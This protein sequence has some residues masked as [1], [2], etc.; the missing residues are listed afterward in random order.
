[1]STSTKRRQARSQRSD[2]RVPPQFVGVD[3]E[4]GN[5]DGMHRYLLLR[6]GDDAVEN[7]QGLTLREC[8]SFLCSLATRERIYV[9]FAFDYDV[10]MMLR[11]AGPAKWNRLFDRKSRE[12]IVD[13]RATGRYWPVSFGEFEVDY[14][15]RKEFKVRRKGQSRYVVVHDV[16]TFFQSS[17]V[18]A[19]RGWFGH[20][21]DGQWIPESP[22]I[23]NIVERIAIGKEQRHD[24]GAVTQDEREYNILEIEMLEWLMSRFRHMCHELAIFPKKWQGPGNLVTAVFRREGM[25]RRRDIV[26]PP[27]VLQSAN[28]GYVGGRFE[29]RSFGLIPERIYQYDINSAYAASYRELPCLLHGGWGE[30]GGRD[31]RERPEME[32]G[33][34]S[35][36]GVGLF[37]VTFKHPTGLAWNTLPV[38]SETGSVL[39]PRE[40]QGWYWSTE[41][42]VA[43]KYG[44]EII[45][46]DGW[47]YINRCDCKPFEW[48]YRL[49]DLRDQVGK[50]SGK[51][52]VLKTTLATIYGK[53]AQSIGNPPYANPVWAGLITSSC[54]ARLVDATLSVQRGQRVHM[55][56][57]DG[58]FS[59]VQIP[60][61]VV[62]RGIGEWELTEHENMFIVQSGVY[63]LPGTKPKTRGVPLGKVLEYEEEFRSTWDSWRKRRD[64]RFDKPRVDIHLMVFI[65][66]RVARQWKKPHLAGHW[67]ERQKRV[68]FD[69]TTKRTRPRFVGSYLVTDPVTGSID[70]ASCPPKRMIGGDMDDLTYAVDEG[71]DW[72]DQL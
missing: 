66:L 42:R 21:D 26:V 43:E 16:F 54:R 30:I 27:R 32:R 60:G 50:N 33:V 28:D 2:R 4:G 14:L 9:S 38:R 61:L 69:W 35:F 70:I 18:V 20:F 63:F 41:L 37:R 46:H 55:L 8:L 39:F 11:S 59:S 15:P 19:L 51:G 29:S 6:A 10:T 36:A 64:V 25:P 62:G 7:D 57:T 53:L 45:V 71:P 5:I 13:G 52:K 49:Y 22:E 31:V 65:G 23:G 56:A 1:M 12:F 58:L 17:F 48:V 40:G 72:A 34:V 68:S 3:G 44:C 47:H 24:F 67:I